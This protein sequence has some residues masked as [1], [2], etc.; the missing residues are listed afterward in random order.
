MKTIWLKDL[1]VVEEVIEEV[2]ET[3][4]EPLFLG[5]K[6]KDIHRIEYYDSCIY[7]YNKNWLEVYC[8]NS[9]KYWRKKEYKDWLK[10]YFENSYGDWRK[11]EDWKLIDYREWKYTIDWKEARLK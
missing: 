3:K 8:E 4:R 6:K 5:M 10:V 11:T 9:S 7:W 2:V 1:E